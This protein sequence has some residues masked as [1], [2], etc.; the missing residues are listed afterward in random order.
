MEKEGFAE[1]VGQ[2]ALAQVLEHEVVCLR[3]RV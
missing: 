1:D 2:L 3:F